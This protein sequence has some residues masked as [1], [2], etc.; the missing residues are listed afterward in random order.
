MKQ[1]RSKSNELARRPVEDWGGEDE[2]FFEDTIFEK[3]DVLKL[4]VS[5][6]YLS[7][8][9]ELSAGLEK[10]N[11]FGNL[12]KLRPES[13]IGASFIRAGGFADDGTFHGFYVLLWRGMSIVSRDIEL[14]DR[15][16]TFL[17]STRYCSSFGDIAKSM[18]ASNKVTLSLGKAATGDILD[19]CV[20]WEKLFSFD[21]DVLSLNNGY[22]KESLD[23][24]EVSAGVWNRNQF[25]DGFQEI[26]DMSFHWPYPVTF[27]RKV[28]WTV[29]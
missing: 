22:T 9:P 8:D 21:S 26:I 24:E 16:I 1:V 12:A 27:H 10:N 25:E 18:K 11:H 23:F 20:H 29:G 3:D 6:T 4:A 19:T 28:W 17:N 13:D 14:S 2:M 7:A 5:K 15:E